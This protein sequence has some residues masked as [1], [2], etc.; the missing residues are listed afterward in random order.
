MCDVD[1]LLKIVVT[2]AK[3]LGIPVS[4]AIEPAIRINTRAKTRLGRCIVSPDGRCQIELA[5]RVVAAGERAC[6]TVLA[7]EVLHSCKGCRNHQARWKSYAGRMNA[8]YGYD[9]RRTHTPEALGILNDCPSR[10]RLQ[11]R[12]CGAVLERMKKSPLVLHPERYRCSCG[13]EFVRL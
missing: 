3:A 13:G 8:A 6:K 9:I 12:R 1:A 7:H 5:A 4:P 11:C 10:Y 2:E